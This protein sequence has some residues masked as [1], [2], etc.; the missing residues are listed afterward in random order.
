MGSFFFIE[1]PGGDAADEGDLEDDKGDAA[2]ADMVDALGGSGNLDLE[3][4]GRLYALETLA[5]VE[6]PDEGSAAEED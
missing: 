1:E 3:E 6:G 2:T 4:R 5:V